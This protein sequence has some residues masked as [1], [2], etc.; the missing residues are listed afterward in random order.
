[1][2]IL[3]PAA[4]LSAIVAAP[5][6]AQDADY[7][8]NQVYIAD[9]EECPASTDEVITVCGVLEDPYRIPRALRQSDSP[10]NISWA[11]RVQRFETVGASGINSCTPVGA[12]GETGCTQ[13]LI[14]QAYEDRRNAPGVRF[15]E[16]IA[17]AREDRLSTIDAD[18]RLEQERVES[19]E[20]E[21][22][23]RLERER[24]GAVPGEATDTPPAIGPATTEAATPDPEG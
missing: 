13:K 20:R 5:A 10:E 8:V 1:M 23:E 9:G 7:A 16:I 21:Y 17:K 15:G 12:G 3:I 22:M 2:K 18:A 14:R 19:I 24:D 6:V 4:I 11:E